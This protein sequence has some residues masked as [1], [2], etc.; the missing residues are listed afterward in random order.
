MPKLKKFRVV[1]LI[2]NDTRH[3]Y[4]EVFD[5][6]DGRHGMMLLANGGGKT[7]LTQMMMQ[8]VIPKT[9]L[10]TRKFTDY[11]KINKKPTL[12]LSEWQLDN[13]AGTFLSGLV[14]KYHTRR[15]RGSLEDK[16]SLDIFAFT[17][18]YHYSETYNIQSIPVSKVDHNGRRSM[19][20]Y[21]S[22]LSDLAKHEKKMPM[23]VNCFKWSDSR[24]AK[25]QYGKKLAEYGI[26]QQEWK[27]NILKI[28]K[29]EAGLKSFFEDAKTSVTLLKRKLLPTIESKL[30]EQVRDKIEIQT[31]VR[32]HAKEEVKNKKIIEERK[33]YDAFLK[34]SKNFLECSISHKAAIDV[35]DE[36]DRTV[37]AALLGMGELKE[38]LKERIATEEEAKTNNRR[39]IDRIKF[40]EECFNYYKEEQQLDMD[41]NNYN[42]LLQERD[43]LSKQTYNADLE[44][45]VIKATK[46]YE[47]IQQGKVRI[48]EKELELERLLSDKDN[49]DYQE[50]VDVLAYKY[51]E[52]KE[53]L[54][55]LL[56]TEKSGELALEKSKNE[57]IDRI[58]E[59]NIE[60]KSVDDEATILKHEMKKFVNKVE[61][62][63]QGNQEFV[64]EQHILYKDYEEEPLNTYITKLKAED[65]TLVNSIFTKEKYIEDEKANVKILEI[66]INDYKIDLAKAEARLSKS[67]ES[68]K[69][70]I[71]Y[72]DDIY[73]KLNKLQVS[74]EDMFD[75]EYVNN[76]LEEVISS[77]EEAIHKATIEKSM[78]IQLFE[79]LAEGRLISLPKEMLQ[80][81][82]K[83]SIDFEYGYKWLKNLDKEYLSTDFFM[84]QINVLPFSLVMDDYNL[85]KFIDITKNYKIN[86]VIPIVSEEYIRQTVQSNQLEAKDQKQDIP[87]HQTSRVVIH[88]SFEKRLLDEGFISE[89]Q[90]F[91]TKQLNGLEND[92]VKLNK[93]KDWITLLINDYIK[94]VGLYSKESHKNLQRQV[95]EIEELIDSKKIQSLEAQKAIEK[96]IEYIKTKKSELEK[97]KEK[98]RIH[99]KSLEEYVLLHKEFLTYQSKKENNY[100]VTQKVKQI[101]IKIE[102]LTKQQEFINKSIRE[103]EEYI[104]SIEGKISEYEKAMME[105]NAKRTDN[106]LHNHRLYKE[107]FETLKAKYK[108]FNKNL[109]DIE[110]VKEILTFYKRELDRLNKELIDLQVETEDYVN[111]VF[112]KNLLHES[113]I[114]FKIHE[115][116]LKEKESM[117]SERKGSI[118]SKVEALGLKK[119]NILSK[120]KLKE[121]MF[122][123]KH[124]LVD[125]SYKERRVNNKIAHEKIKE[126]IIKFNMVNSEV[127]SAINNMK[128]LETD[129]ITTQEHNNYIKTYPVEI[130]KVEVTN[131][132][133]QIAKTFNNAKLNYNKEKSRLTSEYV[134]LKS[135]YKDKSKLLTKMFNQLLIEANIYEHS[136]VQQV[137]NQ[138]TES[139]YR[140]IDKYDADIR[141]LQEKEEVLYNF[142]LTKVSNVYDELK[143]IDKHSIIN[144]HGKREKM[145]YI[146]MPK[147]ETL[148]T[149]T[150]RHYLKE[151]IRIAKVKIENSDMDDL[152]RYLEDH[153]KLE[154]LFSE[155]V[156]FNRIKISISKIEENKVS[157]MNWEQVGKASGGELFV[158][159]FIMFSSLISYTRGIQLSRKQRGTV[160]VMDNPFGPVSSEHLLEPLF[161]IAATYDT[162]MICYTHINT[163]AI[164][165]QFD[166]I[167]SLRVVQESGTGREHIESNIA[168][169]ID[170]SIELIDTAV[171]E[172]GEGDQIGLL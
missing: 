8:P 34:E 51:K 32:Q 56:N 113:E 132:Y 119:A 36:A 13:D 95:L 93:S 129:E 81:L 138:A 150:I 143:D 62:M 64:W 144:L 85:N 165:N 69:K 145:L 98:H 67:Q 74:K 118:K 135:E 68:F 126:A 60:K 161:K 168:K 87:I 96:S 27:D 128:I 9:D 116:Q 22:I 131:E 17:I 139:I 163:S 4:D 49:D 31:L 122:L 37:S 53:N 97:L 65:E 99:S 149:T 141:V 21:E 30:D 109:G 43:E 107:D 3:I 120:R 159:V 94:F 55:K 59:Y 61:Q 48:K 15:K 89:E 78:T 18:Q 71:E 164:T 114:N 166:L 108:I 57:C 44:V 91:L 146:T 106:E 45:R 134:K 154:H 12:L 40:E 104:K 70:Y 7:V 79:S 155:Y 16:E 156:P 137:I 82:E 172:I 63:N 102:E 147:K 38:Q 157:K 84:E 127:E 160:L 130:N 142:V 42:Q 86:V 133:T 41:R 140:I 151:I 110:S 73:S 169:D 111:R 6:G 5:F 77:K 25:E 52:E 14:V 101:D 20:N 123:L 171:F 19:R 72:E 121:D 50:L 136:F 23:Y 58:N 35:K 88:T 46:K 24:E 124:M 11:F 76:Q 112:D 66:N 39:E 80:F 158:S 167:Y 162:Q 2:Y 103:K 115:K 148:D 105:L 90:S 83:N 29:E 1:N 100:N 170:Q 28:N 33:T 75:A 10:K 47:E 54:S 92:I 117:A 152:D 153:L 125:I 26:V